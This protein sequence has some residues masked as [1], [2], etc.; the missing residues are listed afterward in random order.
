MSMEMEFVFLSTMLA[1]LVIL[2]KG[3]A[4]I[5]RDIDDLKDL[6]EKKLF[7]LNNVKTPQ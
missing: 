4:L 5:R 3:I 2:A 1:S 7:S 6:I